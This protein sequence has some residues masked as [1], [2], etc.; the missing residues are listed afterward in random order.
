M[1]LQVVDV[2]SLVDWE[3]KKVVVGLFC[4]DV[5]TREPVLVRVHGFRPY[6]LVEANAAMRLAEGEMAA[7]ALHESLVRQVRIL[8]RQ[9]SLDRREQ[10]ASEALAA[11]ED[12]RYTSVAQALEWTR[13]AMRGGE[14]CDNLATDRV[15][16][17]TRVPDAAGLLN[18]VGYDPQPLAGLF[19][20]EVAL[21]AYVAMVRDVVATETLRVLAEPAP[22]VVRRARG[23]RRATVSE[24]EDED[25]DAADAPAAL[26][27]DWG[28]TGRVFGGSLAPEYQFMVDYDVRGTSDLLDFDDGLGQQQQQQ[29]YVPPNMVAGPG[30]RPIDLDVGD[31]AALRRPRTEDASSSLVFE[32]LLVFDIEVAGAPGKFPHADKA[33][34]PVIQISCCSGLVSQA[35]P[36]RN[37]VF[38]LKRTAD[39]RKTPD[40][41]I[42]AEVQCFESE[43]ALLAAFRDHIVHE[44][45]PDVISGWN[46]EDFDF[47]YLVSRVW[48]MGFDPDL[49]CWSRLAHYQTRNYAATFESSAY[50]RREANRPT[51]PGRVVM[52][53]LEQYRRNYKLR[54][55]KLDEVAFQFL[56]VRKEDVHFSQIT[57]MWQSGDSVQRSKLAL[58]CLMDSV[59][60]FRLLVRHQRWME[61]RAL[62]AVAG[63]PAQATVS[64]G[65][66]IRVETMF[67]RECRAQGFAAPYVPHEGDAAWRDPETGEFARPA[68]GRAA[69]IHAQAIAD[70]TI[71]TSASRA[72]QVGF[73]GATVVDPQRGFYAVPIATLDF[74]GLYPS[75]MRAH[76]LCFSTL[77]K[78]KGEED[79]AETTTTPAGHRFV[80]ASVR[81]GLLPR[82]LEGLYHARKAAKREMFECEKRGDK[83]GATVAN[84]K[85]LALKITSNS[86]YG[87]T[88][89]STSRWYEVAI[90]E[91]VTAYGRVGI[92]T[93]TE[94]TRDF[95][96]DYRV[97]YGDTDSV[98]VDVCLA[99]DFGPDFAETL[100]LAGVL[101]EA[102]ARALRLNDFINERFTRPINLEFEKVFYPYLLVNKKRYAA[103]HYEGVDAAGHLDPAKGYLDVK[104]MESTRRD[105]AVLTARTVKECLR[106]LLH[107]MDTPAALAHARAVVEA[108]VDGAVPLAD[109]VISKAYTRAEYAGVQPHVDLKRRMA[110]R[111][112][113]LYQVQIGD[114]VPYVIVAPDNPYAADTNASLRS[115][116]PEYAEEHGLVPDALYYIQQQLLKPL[117]RIFTPVVGSEAEVIRTL[118]GRL[119]NTIRPKQ[120]LVLKRLSP[121]VREALFGGASFGLGKKGGPKDPAKDTRAIT[122]FF[123]KA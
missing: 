115:E 70:G 76:N 95:D 93:C 100:G 103:M 122:A 33:K 88:G 113:E 67:L 21:Q 35:K 96:P 9:R 94:A 119:R 2:Q 111:G 86:I 120:G 43:E 55:Y 27:P 65:Q 51:I 1:R 16:A 108:L 69:E 102:Q 60:V 29:R 68:A 11:R 59:L 61:V 110:E 83:D 12:V 87:F 71:A 85:Q 40:P 101:R 92:E 72:R 106:I 57:P 53:G 7:L 64:R 46:I 98:M 117:V 118:L 18:A 22:K 36:T 26:S 4:L 15:V 38:C 31:F 75:I 81:K 50:G 105:N 56:G 45:D 48:R 25:D 3:A 28:L 78:D 17:V 79:A 82:I 5:A 91:S 58:Y 63:V 8:D 97:I 34:Y 19:R 109:L 42:V 90:S 39:I 14:E 37:V 121:Q 123:N 41:D 84:S 24:L 77:R 89:A 62:S 10:R 104:G 6:L 54:S 73:Q 49:C 47:Q 74:E 20:V 13:K 66:S 52:D 116:D 99:R 30:V 23:V 80:A 114:R 112:E 44:V 32:T 107:E